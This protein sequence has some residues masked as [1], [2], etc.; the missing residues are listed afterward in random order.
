MKAADIIYNTFKLFLNKHIDEIGTVGSSVAIPIFKSDLIHDLITE[1]IETQKFMH[2]IIVAPPK[3]II[4]GDLHGNLHDLLR[5]LIKNGLPPETNY[6]FLGDYVDR[7]EFSLEVVILVFALRILFPENV[8]LLR[9]NHE[10][11]NINAMYG[12]KQNIVDVYGND[13]L[14]QEFNDAFGYLPLIA[15]IAMQ[16]LCLHG[17]ISPLLTS[18]DPI[19]AIKFPMKEITPLVTDILWSDPS[20]SVDDYDKNDRGCGVIW[21]PK[22]SEETL[23][24]LKYKLIIRGHQCV[25]KGV[26]ATHNNKVITVFSSSNYLPT[27]NLCGYLVLKDMTINR[28]FLDPLHTVQR[29]NAIFAKIHLKENDIFEEEIIEENFPPLQ[30]PTAVSRR[31]STSAIPNLTNAH[32]YGSNLLMVRKK[33]VISSPAVPQFTSAIVLQRRNSQI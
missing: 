31:S 28:G 19:K 29:Q 32:S 30:M 21:S 25:T 17:G 24:R 1:F 7:G 8:F 9:G 12:F 23:K 11:S 18:L 26:E 6:L 33:F 5:I 14:W 15:I 22:N 16:L 3:V 13:T 20:E 4:I 27:G 2:P 10:L